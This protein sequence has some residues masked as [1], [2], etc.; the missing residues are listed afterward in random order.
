MTPEAKK[1]KKWAR[2]Q[3]S[4]RK[5]LLTG[6]AFLFRG[7]EGG[8][9]W[10]KN[11]SAQSHRQAQGRSGPCSGG[12]FRRRGWVV[13]PPP[14]APMDTPAAF[15]ARSV[16]LHVYSLRLFFNAALFFCLLVYLPV[17]LL[18]KTQRICIV[19]VERTLYRPLKRTPHKAQRNKAPPKALR[20]AFFFYRTPPAIS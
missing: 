18:S 20:F 10:R 7:S 3:S 16:E 5:G 14:C 13:G 8:S 12:G 9:T 2:F 15:G 6:A 11:K 17:N 19:F 4:Q 1:K